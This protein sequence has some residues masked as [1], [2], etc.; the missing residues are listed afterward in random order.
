MEN[1]NLSTAEKKRIRQ[2]LDETGNVAEAKR[3]FAFLALADGAPPGEVA[4]WVG[5]S[6]QCLYQW[7]TR[8]Q[9]SSGRPEALMDRS[10]SGRPSPWDEEMRR[11]LCTILEQSPDELGY[12]AVNWIVGLLQKHLEF[13]FG[14][15]LS[16][17]S[18]RRRLHELGYVWKRPRYLLDPDPQREK[19]TGIAPL[20]QE[21]WPSDGDPL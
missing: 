6:R 12:P 20:L 15:S 18:V 9:Q 14:K 13:C 3:L 16:E 4:E 1:W 2:R 10:R 8:Y 21:T 7:R 19:K 5:V 11:C 17:V